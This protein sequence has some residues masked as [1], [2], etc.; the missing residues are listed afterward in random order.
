MDSED[1]IHQTTKDS[2]QKKIKLKYLQNPDNKIRTLYI[3]IEKKNNETNLKKVNK[4]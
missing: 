3:Y 4:V 2:R 1:Q